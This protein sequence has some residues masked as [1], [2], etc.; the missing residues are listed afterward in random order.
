MRGSFIILINTKNE[1]EAAPQTSLIRQGNEN[2]KS[3]SK[4]KKALPHLRKWA[5]S[6]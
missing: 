4:I 6:L 1:E 5:K 2:Y 3:K